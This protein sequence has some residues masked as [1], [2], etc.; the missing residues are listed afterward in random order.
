LSAYR[1]ICL[2]S[3]KIHMVTASDRSVWDSLSQGNARDAPEERALLDSFER[4]E[5]EI[6]L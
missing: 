4:H 3:V 2:A 1:D 6:Y 5:G